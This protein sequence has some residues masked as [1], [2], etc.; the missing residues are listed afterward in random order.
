MA[1]TF[2]LVLHVVALLTMTALLAMAAPHAQLT[3]SALWFAWATFA[4]ILSCGCSNLPLLAVSLAMCGAGVRAA[5]LL[6][7]QHTAMVAFGV[8]ATFFG[9]HAASA[10]FVSLLIAWVGSTVVLACCLALE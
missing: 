3:P 7:K 5:R 8:P 10:C 6:H 1:S 2:R 4:S 9:E